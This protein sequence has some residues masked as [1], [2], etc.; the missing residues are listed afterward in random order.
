[1]KLSKFKDSK[2]QVV[3]IYN[4]ISGE[5]ISSGEIVTFVRVAGC[6]LRCRYCDTRYSYQEGDYE[7]LTPL[8]IL[9]RVESF[10]TDKVICTGGEPLVE[11]AAKRYL[12][13]FLATEGY[14][15]R[16]ESNGSWPVYKQ[17]EFEDFGVDSELELYYTLDVKCPSSEMAQ[18][19]DFSNFDSLRTGDELKFVVSNQYDLDYALQVI[20]NHKDVLKGIVLNFSPAYTI[21]DPEEI[22]N[23][24]QEHQDYFYENNLDTRL[25]LQLHK[26]IWDADRTGV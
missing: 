26:I 4:S 18:A 1:M 13:L 6:N 15:V 7:R 2:L 10:G 11:E 22:V 9:E 17:K 16:I 12:P 5:G 20:K 8:E 23:F 21:I 24:L 3:E 25:S 14:E 19:N